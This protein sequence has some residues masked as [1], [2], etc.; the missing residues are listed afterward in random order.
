MSE[1]NSVHI[2]IDDDISSD[3]FNKIQGVCD[4]DGFYN[5]FDETFP[6]V[7]AQRQGIHELNMNSQGESYYHFQWTVLDDSDNQRYSIT[8]GGDTYFVLF[9]S[10]KF[11]DGK[12]LAENDR[13]NVEVSF[14]D[15]T[16]SLAWSY[17]KMFVLVK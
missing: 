3:G 4:S 2:D 11:N 17:S 7:D 1:F 13:L 10:A 16:G 6:T 12:N 5:V 8:E 14:I 9:S 15:L